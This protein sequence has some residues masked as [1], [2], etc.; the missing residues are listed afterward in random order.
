[1]SEKDL[2]VI[3]GGP[4]GYVAALRASQLGAGVTLVEENKLGGVC[5]NRGCIPT[6]FLLHAT[7]VYKSMKN[8]EEYGI[9]VTGVAMDITKLQQRKTKM[10]SNLVSG[11]GHLLTSASVEVINGRARLTSPGNIEID[12]GQAEKQSLQAKNI[13]I[14]TGGRSAAVPIPGAD[15]PDIMNYEDLLNLDHV[16]ESMI[17]IGG[18]VIGVEMATVLNQIDCK[19]TIIEMMPRIIPTQ[20]AE[21]VSVID[22]AL[23][24]DGVNIYC[25]AR[26]ESIESAGDNKK[27]VFSVDGQTQTIEAESVAITTGQKPNIEGLGL[28]ECRVDVNGGRIVTDESMRTNVP[29]IYAAGDVTG[30]MML[31]HIGFA[32][33][34]IAAENALGQDSAMDYSAVPQCIFTSPEIASVGLS[35]EESLAQGYQIEIGRFPFAA[36]GMA[37]ILGE[38]RGLV[39]II[40]EK[41]YSRIIGVHIA[42]PSASGLIAEAALA[43]KME[44]TPQEIV[45]TIHAHPTLSETFW[46]SA[47]DVTGESLHFP[48]KNRRKS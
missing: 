17:I 24:A 36:S 2:V 33:G 13:I 21:M 44:L 40:T 23:K 16:P 4:A 27:V 47:L 43:M 35:E 7:D 26:V 1:M 30:G 19:V 22:G 11:V 42:G 5:L 46:E 29:G 8:S 28:E 6:K 48:S 25:G 37:S 38:T 12:T 45:E 20:D 39:K 10:I 31:A 18:G 3:G 34:R 15:S 32:E 9:E 14:A 41:Q